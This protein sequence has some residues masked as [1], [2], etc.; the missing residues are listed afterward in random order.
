MDV[1]KQF[2]LDLAAISLEMQK[3]PPDKND[4]GCRSSTR[5]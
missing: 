4:V 2:L 3:K 1:L 5:R